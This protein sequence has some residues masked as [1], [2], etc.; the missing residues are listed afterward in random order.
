[1]MMTIE[2]LVAEQV[3]LKAARSAAYLAYEMAKQAFE[4]NH[5]RL[6]RSLIAQG[7]WEAGQVIRL[8]SGAEVKIHS[9]RASDDGAL[10]AF[11]H[12]KTGSGEWS[13]KPRMS[14]LLRRAPVVEFDDGGMAEERARHP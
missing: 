2:T 4:E 3:R 5:D 11:C 12:D 7:P 6:T 14:I 13:K 9:M 10:T 1:M 8:T